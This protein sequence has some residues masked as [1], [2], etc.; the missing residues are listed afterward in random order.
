M[1]I[2]I[3]PRNI[4]EI[5]QYCKGFDKLNF[6]LRIFYTLSIKKDN[7]KWLRYYNRIPIPMYSNIFTIH[8]FFQ[9]TQYK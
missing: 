4:N 5:C 1:Q 3:F 8:F 6:D 2:Y 7:G 9:Y